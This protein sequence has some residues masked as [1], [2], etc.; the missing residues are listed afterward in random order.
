LRSDVLSSMHSKSPLASGVFQRSYEHIYRY[1]EE[2]TQCISLEVQ[3][4]KVL[5]DVQHVTSMIMH[6]SAINQQAHYW[7]FPA[8][9]P[10]SFSRAASQQRDAGIPPPLIIPSL[11]SYSK[12]REHPILTPQ[13]TRVEP[14]QLHRR[15]TSLPNL[16]QFSLPA[17]SSSSP[18]AEASAPALKPDLSHT[19]QSHILTSSAAAVESTTRNSGLQSK[20]SP[21][22]HPQLP[23]SAE[24]PRTY[25]QH[26]QTIDL[27][28]LS[29]PGTTRSNSHVS[30][31]QQTG[32]PS[33]LELGP[34]FSVGS[35]A[36]A[37]NVPTVGPSL[38]RLK[39]EPPQQGRATGALTSPQTVATLGRSAWD[40]FPTVTAP[41]R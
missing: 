9:I 11:P 38:F 8:P 13:P 35:T 10:T 2:K 33:A 1:E 27:L 15:L 41:L 25:D 34:T 21:G 28:F 29:A 3:M 4:T 6:V 16:E 19:T 22:S 39:S 18:L 26:V 20:F 37:S 24:S 23:A 32:W 40:A 7:Q 12:P 14:P 5:D 31:Q 17:L 30:T 36:W